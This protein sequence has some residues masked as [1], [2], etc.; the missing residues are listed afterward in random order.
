MARVRWKAAAVLDL[1]RSILEDIAMTTKEFEH[2]LLEMIADGLVTTRY[3]AAGE[4]VYGLTDK[5]L[6]LAQQRQLKEDAE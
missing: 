4:L 2:L 5:G 6:A 3:N 1:W